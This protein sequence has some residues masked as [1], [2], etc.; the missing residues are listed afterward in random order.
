MGV[1][2]K[3]RAGI[4]FRFEKWVTGPINE[5]EEKVVDE[6]IKKV[7][8]MAE[9]W[10]KTP[11]LPIISN[12]VN[13]ANLFYVGS[14]VGLHTNAFLEL[15]DDLRELHRIIQ[16]LQEDLEELKEKVEDLEKELKEGGKE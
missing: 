11:S 14:V 1:S 13:E 15:G 2:G 5:E 9:E 16:D 7:R 4:R 6:Y 8:E 12:A 10:R 3:E